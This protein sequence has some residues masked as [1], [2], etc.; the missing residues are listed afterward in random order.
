MFRGG[1]YCALRYAEKMSHV[2]SVGQQPGFNGPHRDP[3]AHSRNGSGKIS[4][5]SNRG[6][7]LLVEVTER[8][9]GRVMGGVVEATK[10]C[11]ECGDAGVV[12]SS[13]R[14]G[15]TGKD[16]S[17]DHFIHGSFH[18]AVDWKDR[19]QRSRAN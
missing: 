8:K 10:A 12:D 5:R 16:P 13:N 1:G 7:F 3:E 11:F 4:A 17:H 2:F 15:Q 6:T 19:H 14:D 18:E 9:P